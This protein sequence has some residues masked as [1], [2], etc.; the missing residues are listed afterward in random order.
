ML[1]LKG[2]NVRPNIGVLLAPKMA[3]ELEFPDVS[4]MLGLGVCEALLCMTAAW[5]RFILKIWGNS[6]IGW[7]VLISGH[8][9]VNASH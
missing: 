9:H 8:R 3:G 2:Q 5:R 1:T 4:E 7:N 6:F